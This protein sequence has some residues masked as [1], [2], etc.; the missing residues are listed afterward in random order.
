M[1]K[2]NL[3]GQLCKILWRRCSTCGRKDGSAFEGFGWE[4]AP[5][6]DRSS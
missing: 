1:K 2:G 5:N 6:H 4:E 3:F